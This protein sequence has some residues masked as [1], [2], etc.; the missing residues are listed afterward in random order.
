[1]LALRSL[2]VG[3]SLRASARQSTC[4]FEPLRGPSG[5]ERGNHY[6]HH[7]EHHP[8]ILS[9]LA[10]DDISIHVPVSPFAFFPFLPLPFTPSPLPYFP[11]PFTLFK[12]RA[13]SHCHS[14]RLSGIQFSRE[15]AP[16]LVPLWP[17]RLAE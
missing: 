6:F 13:V 14:G 10:Q 4:H 12:K 2:G 3:G 5:S 9:Q 8:V 7:P 15:T 17:L 1:M 16:V 11:F